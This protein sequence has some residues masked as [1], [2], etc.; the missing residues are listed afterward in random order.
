MGE[1]FTSEFFIANRQRLRELFTGTAPIVVTANGLLQR[2]ADTNYKYAQDANFWYLTG[3]E[4]SDL[5]LVMDRDKEYLIVPGRSAS[6]A[7]FDGAVTDEAVIRRS[8]VATVYDDKEGWDRLG[9]RLK[10]VKH[11]ATLAPPPAYIDFYGMYTNPARASL[12]QKLKDYNAELKLLDLAP[13]LIRMR[14]IKQPAE[15]VAIQAAV[16]I[17]VETLKYCLKPAR[18][19]KY[20]F[21]YELEADVSSGFRKRGAAG[22]AFDPIVAGGQR[23]CTMHYL[24]NNHALSADELVLL[25]IGSEVEHYASD[26]ART[27]ALGSPS[28]R[29][30][31]VYAAVL[32]AE[33]FAFSLLRPGTSLTEYERQVELFIGEKLRELNLLKTI[34]SVGVRKFF[35]HRTSHFVG[36]T[37]HDAGDYERP[38][39]PGVVLAVETGIYIPEE[40]IGVRIEDNVVITDSGIKVLSQK[41]PRQ[42]A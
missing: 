32:E 22:H 15:L 39:E 35:P 31:A 12:V 11:V 6:R 34:D 38:L 19:R 37:A 33:D 2:T 5:V 13:H 42:V 14:M 10:K 26:I 9:S 8:G 24:S 36:L 7:I 17:T 4:E 25:D 28:R 27:V 40:S 29:Q 30:Q 23:A 1:L 20:S 16:D 41:L 18:L 3:L 21:E